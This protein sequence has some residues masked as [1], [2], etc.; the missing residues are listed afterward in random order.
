MLTFK[1]R[2]Q[3]GSRFVYITRLDEQVFPPKKSHSQLLMWIQVDRTRCFGNKKRGDQMIRDS[4]RH[5]TKNPQIVGGHDSQPLS[6]GHVFFH[7]PKRATK[8]ELPERGISE[9]WKNR[10][11]CFEFHVRNTY[12]TLECLHAGTWKFNSSPLKMAL[13]KRKVLFQPSFF[14]GKNVKLRRCTSF[15][16][17]CCWG[18]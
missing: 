13:P 4:S 11:T 15:F 9:T 6:S 12:Y 8:A 7:H 2:G 10:P 14:R 1:N 18:G 5:P 17:G 16:D 3:L